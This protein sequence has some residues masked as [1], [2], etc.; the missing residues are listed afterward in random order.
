VSDVDAV[1]LDLLEK[2]TGTPEVRRN[3]D[4]DLF[5][6]AILDS[7]GVVEMIAGLSENLKITVAPSEIERDLWST[8]RRIMAFVQSR[9]M[10]AA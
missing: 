4:I 1:V 2:V 9:E 3:L 8:P 6:E 5:E 7:L 10:Q